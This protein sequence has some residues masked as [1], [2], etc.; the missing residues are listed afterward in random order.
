MAVPNVA[1]EVLAALATG[2]MDAAKNV[3]DDCTKMVALS[4]EAASYAEADTALGSGAGKKI[5]EVAV[6]A[7]DFA[8][9]GTGIARKVTFGGKTG[10]SVVVAGPSNPTVVALLR[11]SDSTILAQINET[12]AS[13]F[14]SGDTPSFPPGDILVFVGVS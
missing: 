10:G 6:V 7:A 1:A 4:A 12:G 2:G 8:V 14:S 11:T 5:A 3:L 9:A 13:S